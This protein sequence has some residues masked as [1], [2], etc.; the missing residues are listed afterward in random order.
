M[1]L[2]LGFDK[3]GKLRHSHWLRLIFAGGWWDEFLSRS[4]DF[5]CPELHMPVLPANDY[6]SARPQLVSLQICWVHAVDTLF[7]LVSNGHS[8]AT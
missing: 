5:L 4:G 8:N 6:D 7:L 3:H 2:L 1:N